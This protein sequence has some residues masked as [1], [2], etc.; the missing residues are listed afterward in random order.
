MRPQARIEVSALINGSKISSFQIIIFSLCT[1]CL[2]MDGFDLQAL[3]YV[4]PAVAR[5]FKVPSAE[6]GPVFGAAN[7]GLLIGTVLFS[8]LA[9]KIGRR[10]VL[11]GATAFFAAVT[12]ATARVTSVQYLLVLRFIAGIGLGAVIPNVTALA[13][14][15]APRK[16]RVA[17]IMIVTSIGLNGGAMVGGFV[18]AWLIPTFGWRSVFYVGGVAPLL[19]A[20]LMV[21][22]LPE[23]MQFLALVKKRHEQLAGWAKRIDPKTAAG[24]ASEYIVREE[25]RRGVPALHLF[26]DGRA[27]TTILLWIVNFMNL[28][29]LYFL[30]SWL[31]SVIHDAGYSI[32]SAV[33]VA[34]A[35][36]IGGIT[37]AF[38]LAWLIDRRGFVPVLTTSLALACVAVTAIGWPG[39]S[40]PFLSGAVFIAG[41]CVIG[42]Q[43]GMNALAAMLYPTYLRSSGV[44]WSLG[45]GRVGAIA[46]PV[47]GGEL[48]RLQWPA[49][50]IFLA[51]AMPAVISMAAVFSL[52]WAGTYDVKCRS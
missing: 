11:I 38:T 17:A 33:L 34:T 39:L 44:G 4:A 14:E 20:V 19:I 2:L 10:P 6:L 21:F 22:F 32:S 3:G 43:L 1:L 36:Q 7:V 8:M 40:L 46:G 25:Y 9:D 5:D 29:V 15:Y 41:W 52:R 37:G 45:V 42:S 50:Q 13:G 27:V 30:S 28:L 49:Q 16:L 12:L 35:L 18:S 24:A 47:I 51:A 31:P 23:S 48:I 26:R